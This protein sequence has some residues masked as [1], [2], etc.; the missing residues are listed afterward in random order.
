MAHSRNAEQ[1]LTSG[2]VCVRVCMCVWSVC[3]HVVFNRLLF[4][5]V[6]L[7]VCVCMVHCA[8]LNVCTAWM[9]VCAS[10]YLFVCACVCVRILEYG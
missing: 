1:S 6:W 8:R 3:A 2:E 5:F 7:R 4:V 9:Y 10:V